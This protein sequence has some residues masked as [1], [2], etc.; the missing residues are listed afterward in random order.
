[1]ATK[2]KGIEFTV[3][4]QAMQRVAK[5][6]RGEEDGKTL[7]KELVG[8]LKDAVGPGVSKVQ[9]KLRSVPHASASRSS[10]PLGS[11]LASRVKPQV[12]LSGRST[13]VAVRIAQT[14]AIRGF[15]MAARRLNRQS[16]RRRV[17]GH[18]VWV[19]QNSPIPGYFDDTL[20]EGKPEYRAGVIRALEKM[21]SRV[22]RSA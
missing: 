1:V 10:P 19:V 5:A 16:W 17:F 4:Q 11:Y 18:D 7:R 20:A 9:G 13:G 6:M 21:A 8:E 15:K 2:G 12:R 22:A 3:D 14:P